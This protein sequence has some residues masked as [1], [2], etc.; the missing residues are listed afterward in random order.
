MATA[1][2]R[3]PAPAGRGPRPVFMESQVDTLR[4]A[5][6]LM[7]KL[8]ISRANIT[9]HPITLALQKAAILRWNGDFIYLT[10]EA[11]DKLTYNDPGAAGAETN[12]QMA[13]KLQL[14]ALLSYYHELSHK[15]R[16]G[17]S[18]NAP[19]RTLTEFKEFRATSYDPTQPIVP[20]WKMTAKSEGLSNWNKSIK[21]NARDFKPFREMNLWIEYKESFLITLEAQNLTHLVE[22][23]PIIHDDDLDKAQRKFLFKVMKDNFLHHEAKS[24][25][26]KYTTDK[27]TRKIWE[28]LCDFYDSSITTAMCADVLMAYLADVKLHKA[29]WNRGQGE[30]INHYKIQKNKFNEIA[31]DSQITDPHAVRMLHNVVSGT[32]NLAP[33]LNQYRQAR[34]AAGSSINISFDECC[35]L[36]SEQAQVYDNANTRTKSSYRRTANVHDLVGD[37]MEC[38]ANVH[39]ANDYDNQEPDLSE[40]LEVNVSQRPT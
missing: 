29:N 35:A 16:G 33:V 40:I 18:I 15:K 30:F 19:Q 37:D 21:P 12:L 7:N 26:K 32:P 20:W 24:I 27:D 38:E 14:R 36:S 23:N 5:T 4:L 1:A 3:G 22:K 10:A 25:V 11:I 31:P 2:G 17:I 9:R 8:E 39:K 28:E 13:C 34:K 6:A